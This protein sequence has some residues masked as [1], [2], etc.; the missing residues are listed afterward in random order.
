MNSGVRG[1]FDP[2][3]SNLIFILLPLQKYSKMVCL[4]KKKGVSLNTSVPDENSN[5][6]SLREWEGDCVR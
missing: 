4:G 3:Q 6:A 1:E 5:F 2:V